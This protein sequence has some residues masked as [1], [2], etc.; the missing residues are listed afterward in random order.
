[1]NI[2]SQYW[3]FRLSVIHRDEMKSNSGDVAPR[4]L[5]QIRY[6]NV[7]MRLRNMRIMSDGAPRSPFHLRLLSNMA[8]DLW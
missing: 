1:M 7:F 6:L 2:S 5:H 8:L 4:D 3:A